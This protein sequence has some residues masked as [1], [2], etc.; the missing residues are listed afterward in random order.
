M[1]CMLR[2]HVKCGSNVALIFG[3]CPWFPAARLKL[4]CEC[5]CVYLQWSLSKEAGF[6]FLLIQAGSSEVGNAAKSLWS[7]VWL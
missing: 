4:N 5:N 7:F 1:L 3:K 2:K 6:L